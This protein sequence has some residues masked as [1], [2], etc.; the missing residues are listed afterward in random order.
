M[1]APTIVPSHAPY[2]LES[3][4]GGAAMAEVKLTLKGETAD[5]LERLV[6][7]A[8]YASPEAV[9]ADA[10]EALEHSL[11]PDLE[12]WLHDV[13]AHRLDAMRAE[14]QTSLTVEQVRERLFGKP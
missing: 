9:I 14:P 10:L 6:R 8:A 11:A 2:L 12:A 1:G 4:L 3:V 5:R 13:A 7:D